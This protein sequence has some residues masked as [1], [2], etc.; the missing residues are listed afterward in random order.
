MESKNIKIVDE[1][2]IDRIANIVCSIDVD[3]SD[4][5]IY[6]I[7]R[8]NNN[9]NLFISKIL[10]NNDGTSTM[11]NIEDSME[12]SNLSEIVKELVT[13]AVKDNEHDYLNADNISL[14]NG[15]NIKI[16]NVLFNKEQNINVQ[17][18]YITTVEKAA[19]KVTEKYYHVE[20]KPEVVMEA[21]PVVETQAP[22][23]KPIEMPSLEEVTQTVPEL[24]KISPEV[25]VL[26]VPFQN[27]NPAPAPIPEIPNDVVET[28]VE[29]VM[30]EVMPVTPEIA[31]ESTPEVVVPVEPVVPSVAPEIVQPMV[32][33]PNI[34]A[35][36]NIIGANPAPQP[37]PEPEVVPV[38]V[39]SVPVTP[40]PVVS[41][42]APAPVTPEPAVVAPVVPE[43]ATPV[44]P[45]PEVPSTNS[46]QPELFFDGSKETN[47]AGVFE[48]NSDD[49][50]PIVTA[51]EVASIREFGQDE[52][53][54]PLV[55][56]VTPAV[57]E[58]PK[59]LTKSPGFANNKFFLVIALTFFL[60][61]CVFLGYEVFKYIQMR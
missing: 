1:H 33:E 15:K 61:S 40:E 25:P 5:V 22:E 12:K 34:E 9:D 57:Q 28:V 45:T 11:M 17:K 14:K 55:N 51:P 56:D 48:G 39:P 50:Q 16:S 19:T 30:P 27:E 38:A 13:T 37:V 35:R 44:A 10:K 20:K 46:P 18:T 47:L 54:I 42:V 24:E 2:G 3:G 26:E 7:E 8:D 36:M 53:V 31:P 6:W 41:Q 32:E 49:T 43:Q 59:T 29:P 4:Y 23:V 21:A 60:A 52:P 58:Q